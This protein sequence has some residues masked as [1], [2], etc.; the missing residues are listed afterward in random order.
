MKNKFL[1][2]V[3]AVIIKPS[4]DGTR[5]LLCQ[6][7]LHKKYDNGLWCFPGGKIEA[8]ENELD[9]IAREI[10]GEIGMKVIPKDL[11][12]QTINDQPSDPKFS[13]I[14]TLYFLCRLQ[15]NAKIIEEKHDDKPIDN[16]WLPPQGLSA[17]PLTV[18]AAKAVKKIVK[19]DLQKL[20]NL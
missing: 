10:L 15:E 5:V 16:I 3:R 9:A 12:L 7:P 6:N 19:I 2:V 8:G 11:L 17:L 20:L 4:Q 14:L 13:S 18:S 1:T